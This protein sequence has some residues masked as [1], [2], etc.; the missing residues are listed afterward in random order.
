MGNNVTRRL[1]NY[2]LTS[3]SCLGNY[4]IA[5]KDLTRANFQYRDPVHWATIF[6]SAGVLFGGLAVLLAFIQFR[7][8]REDQ[9]RAQVSKVGV[10][11]GDPRPPANPAAGPWLIP[12]FMRNSS[13]LPVTVKAADLEVMSRGSHLTTVPLGRR[14]TVI[15]GQTWQEDY[16]YWEEP[17]DEQPA[18]RELSVSRMTVTDAAGYTWDIRPGW[19]GRAQRIQP[20]RTT[21]IH[22]AMRRMVS[23]GSDG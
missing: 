11:T 22:W 6:T 2:V 16:E 9:L 8:L 21:L 17:P 1:G 14:V 10:W 12:V 3:R 13:Q 15:P 5:D 7:S 19:G 4:V 18:P 20:L 23:P